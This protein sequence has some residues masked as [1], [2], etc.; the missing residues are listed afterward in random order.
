MIVTVSI[1][2]GVWFRPT[3]NPKILENENRLIIIGLTAIPFQAF[4]FDDFKSNITE[5]TILSIVIK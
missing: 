5:T 4:V 1:N 3:T 2:I